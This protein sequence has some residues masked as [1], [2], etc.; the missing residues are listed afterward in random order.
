VCVL[1]LFLQRGKTEG[2]ERRKKREMK[3]SQ[4]PERTTFTRTSL[5][6]T[7]LPNTLRYFGKLCRNKKKQYNLNKKPMGI[8][9]FKYEY[10]TS[11]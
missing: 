6:Q 7:D 8:T 10:K 1:L 5:A 11:G 4:R 2:E 9:S 3:K